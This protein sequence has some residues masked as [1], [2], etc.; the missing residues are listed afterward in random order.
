M[1]SL[2]DIG[3]ADGWRCWLCDEVVDPA[4]SPNDGRAG[5]IDSRITK[6][7]AKKKSKEALAPRLAH[8]QCNTGKG[9][10]VPVIEWPGEL[11]IVDPAAIIASSDRLVRKGGR[12]IMG[13]CPTHDDAESAADWLV[14]RLG[15][16]HPETTFTTEITAAA[17]QH[18][19]V[20]QR[21]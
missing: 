13:R 2:D 4:M 8:R 14:D 21:A 11:F 18:M 5:S 6:S 1:S 9:A 7:K 19:V 20:L 15:R 16:L 12:E 17:G 10:V 3:H